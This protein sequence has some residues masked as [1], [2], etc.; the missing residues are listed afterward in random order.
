MAAR[1]AAGEMRLGAQNF[2]S[3]VTIHGDGDRPPLY[4][5]HTHGGTASYCWRFLPYLGANQP[6]YAL[7]SRA[8]EGKPA[9]KTIE[10]MASHYADE[11]TRA[12]AGPYHL[13]GYCSAGF[14]A[15]EVAKQL[16][17]RGERV[18]LL[19]MFNT[20]AANYF[21]K[22]WHSRFRIL[23][24]RARLELLRFVSGRT[25]KRF[26]P[27]LR[28]KTGS[29]KKKLQPA[30]ESAVLGNFPIK[31]NLDA[32]KSYRP[33]G[34]LLTPILFFSTPELNYFYASPPVHS[35][36]ALTR[37]GIQNLELPEFTEDGLADVHIQ[38]ISGHLRE[39][40]AATRRPA[41]LAELPEREPVATNYVPGLGTGSLLLFDV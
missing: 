1:A 2:D 16:E 41:R 18:A 20:P 34:R 23:A 32:L 35:W 31:T 5:F 11:M 13:F 6:V 28:Q 7:H 37:S 40:M 30:A 15:F 4:F 26:I 27:W 8:L 12:H 21:G 29:F 14:I 9:Q 3:L 39:L 10:E 19:G 36:D 22:N 24:Q 25:Q 38:A 33:A 17:L